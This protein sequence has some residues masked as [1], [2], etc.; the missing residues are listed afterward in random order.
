VEYEMPND[1]SDDT[2]AL[3]DLLGW[4]AAAAARILGSF[5]EEAVR[6]V[7]VPIL[8]ARS[9]EEADAAGERPAAGRYFA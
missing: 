1:G 7:T 3:G 2:R 5:V 9:V 4:I 6:R 8:L